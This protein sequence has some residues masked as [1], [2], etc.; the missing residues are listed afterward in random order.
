H[1]RSGWFECRS[2][3]VKFFQTPRRGHP[4]G[5]PM[6]MNFRWKK[7]AAIYQH[8]LEPNV[9]PINF[10]GLLGDTNFLSTHGTSPRSSLNLAEATK[11]PPES[12]R[13]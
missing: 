6:T 4:S 13:S 8:A 1:P 7:I 12:D 11:V 10:F 3:P 5:Y 2:H 9:P